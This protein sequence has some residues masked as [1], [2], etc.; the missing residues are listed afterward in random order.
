MLDPSSEASFSVL[1]QSTNAFLDKCARE[2]NKFTNIATVKKVKSFKKPKYFIKSEKI[3]LR[4]YRKLRST[5]ITSTE[6]KNLSEIHGR[7]KSH[8][9]QLIRYIKIQDGY[10]RDKILDGLCSSDPSTAF[11]SIKSHLN[12]KNRKISKLQ[13]GKR[14]YLGDQVPD[15][16]YESI[17]NLKTVPVSNVHDDDHPDF[18]EEYRLILDIC[19][20]GKKIPPL[21]REKSAKILDYIRK[22]VNDFY[23][24][25]ALHYVNAG[26]SGY[27]HFHHLLNA[28]IENVNLTGLTELNTIYACI[29]FKGHGKDRT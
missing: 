29:L 15:G 7:H 6:Y 19:K 27:E 18:S 4:S 21:T 13:V 9:N 5:N 1:I 10:S 24:I 3:L 23:S 8:H 20:A 22:N 26:R 28:I 11:K 25:T 16:M 12:S 2:T 14:T 17:K